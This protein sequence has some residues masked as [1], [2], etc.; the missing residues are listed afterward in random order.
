MVVGSSAHFIP[1]IKKGNMHISVNIPENE[2]KTG[3]T[4]SPQLTVEKDHRKEDRDMAG[5]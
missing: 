3:S 2:P 1:Q 4:D 5:S